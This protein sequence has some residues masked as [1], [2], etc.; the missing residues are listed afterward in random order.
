MPTNNLPQQPITCAI[1]VSYNFEAWMDSCIPSV[2]QSTIPVTI[3]VVDNASS[4]ETCKLLKAKYPQVKLIENAENLGFGQANNIGFRYAMENNFDY[5]FLLNQD[6]RIEKN[7]LE[8]LVGEAEKNNY[9]GIISPLHLNGNGDDFDFGFKTYTNLSEIDNVPKDVTECPFINAAMWLVPIKVIQKV[10]GFAPIF[11][12]YGEDVNYTQRVRYHN[13]KI[14]FAPTAIGYHS[15]EN[16]EVSRK[17]FFYIEFVYFLTEATNILYTSVQ[18]FAFS[19]LAAFKKSFSAAFKGEFIDAKNYMKIAFR[20]V[21]NAKQINLSRMR[22]K[23][24]NA[25]YL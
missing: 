24:K 5:V 2:L 3:L 23:Q 25:P 15:R 11:S 18:A 9:F 19:L 16:R 21:K 12:H 20:L 22:T 10:G 4:D 14:V 7:T 13:F 8:I 6:A 17:Q 1:I